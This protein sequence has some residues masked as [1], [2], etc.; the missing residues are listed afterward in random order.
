MVK[1]FTQDVSA[2]DRRNRIILNREPADLVIRGGQV[3]DVHTSLIEQGGIAVAD[4]RIAYVGEVED[5]IGP[6][7]TVVDADGRIAIPGLIEG[8]IHTYESHL[9]IKEIARGF[10]RHGVTTIVTDFYGELVVRGIDAI[11]ASLA[12]S[13]S[14]A[15]NTVF[16]L[17][18]PALSNL[19]STPGPSE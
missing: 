8:H 9:P 19:S 17:P 5:L 12:E 6:Q 4:G 16:I 14:T 13:A 1:S 18:M 3:L 2:R 7:T 11:R 15:L 10:F